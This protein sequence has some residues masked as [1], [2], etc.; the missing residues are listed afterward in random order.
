MSMMGST[1]AYLEAAL[2]SVEGLVYNVVDSSCEG[3]QRMLLRM[4]SDEGAGKVGQVW[5]LE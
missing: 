2:S 1:C 4:E 5:G 3:G